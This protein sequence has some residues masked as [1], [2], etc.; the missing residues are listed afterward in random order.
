MRDSVQIHELLN[1]SLVNVGPL[2]VMTL[3][4]SPCVAKM[5]LSCSIVLVAVIV[6]MLLASNHFEWASTTTINM[7]LR[8]GRAKSI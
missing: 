6:V 3:R 4:G 1:C 5:I 7:W 8:N 2:S